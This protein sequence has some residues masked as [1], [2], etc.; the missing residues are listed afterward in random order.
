[1]HIFYYLQIIHKLG[2]ENIFMYNTKEIYI[3]FEKYNI[4]FVQKY[5]E[6]DIS[7]LEADIIK[8]GFSKSKYKKYYKDTIIYT[9]EEDN[10]FI[11]GEL[12][13]IVSNTYISLYDFDSISESESSN[14]SNDLEI[15]E[16]IKNIDYYI[17]TINN[18]KLKN[19]K[20]Y[21]NE[22]KS[23][24]KHVKI[25]DIYDRDSYMS[26]ISYI[27][28]CFKTM[29]ENSDIVYEFTIA[30]LVLKY[31]DYM[32]D[33]KTI[34]KLLKYKSKKDKI[35]NFL[36]SIYLSQYD[37]KLNINKLKLDKCLSYDG[38]VNNIYSIYRNF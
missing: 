35:D 20:L 5:N 18:I 24:I 16:E 36:R 28:K 14:E 11:K 17:N 19:L 9:I 3:K 34:T 23:N 2:T 29:Y 25:I 21:I 15:F 6:V 26:Q 37:I 38:M 22:F 13:K 4:I 10:F 32:F 8:L 31:I 7:K 30:L 1:M 27:M 12:V 33:F